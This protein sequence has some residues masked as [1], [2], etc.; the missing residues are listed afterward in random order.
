[1][2]DFT[3]DE[4]VDL[5]YRGLQGTYFDELVRKSGHSLLFSELVE[6]SYYN[7]IAAGIETNVDECVAASSEFQSRRRTP[8]VYCPHDTGLRAALEGNG[9]REWAADAWLVADLGDV[10]QPSSAGA[11]SVALLDASNMNEVSGY[12]DAFAAAYS[13]EDPS[14]PYGA[15]D[16]GYLKALKRSV[17]AGGNSD[18]PSE[19]LLAR[20]DGDIAGVAQVLLCGDWVGVY[21]V[22]TIT[23][24]RKKGVGLSLMMGCSEVGRNHGAGKMFLQTEVKSSNQRWY[25]G[26]GFELAFTAPYFVK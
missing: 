3:V 10:L 17:L 13:G 15:L 21:G 22:G 25:E 26:M 20:I 23:S 7:Y 1:M 18:I 9:F 16:P 14:D 24:A 11:A 4:L 6:D 12:L 2:V 8:A 19:F 5:H